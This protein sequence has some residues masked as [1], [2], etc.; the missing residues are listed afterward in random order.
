MLNANIISGRNKTVRH[1]AMATTNKQTLMFR[2]NCKHA[3]NN[4][5]LLFKKINV[6][7]LTRIL[8]IFN[9]GF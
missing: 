1:V 4:Y 9:N 3:S 7:E 8:F 6:Q 5:Y 2:P